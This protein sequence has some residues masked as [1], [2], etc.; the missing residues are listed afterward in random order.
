MVAIVR[1]GKEKKANIK[2]EV[3]GPPVAGSAAA[4]PKS[5]LTIEL[6]CLN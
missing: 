1:K 4:D 2:I 5:Q 6:T 3:A